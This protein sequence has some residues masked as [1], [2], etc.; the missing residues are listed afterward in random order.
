[1]VNVEGIA[2]AVV[3]DNTAK[4]ESAAGAEPAN[5]VNE[6]VPQEEATPEQAPETEQPEPEAEL[7]P[8]DLAIQ[9]ELAWLSGKGYVSEGTLDVPKLVKQTR[10]LEGTLTKFSALSK[11]AEKLG[12]PSQVQSIVD[13]YSGFMA[14]LQ[15][16]PE[17]R[18]K[19]E[20]EVLIPLR[21]G[22]VPLAQP[23]LPTPPEA[24]NAEIAKEVQAGNMLKAVQMALAHSPIAADLERIKTATAQAQAQA[25]AQARRAK[26]DEDWRGF[27]GG[28]PEIMT[29][30]VHDQ[31]MFDKLVAV[32]YEYDPQGEGKMTFSRAYALAQAELGRVPSGAPKQKPQTMARRPIAAPP[33]RAEKPHSF[34]D[35]T[36]HGLDMMLKAP[37]L[38]KGK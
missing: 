14:A 32:K 24:I 11:L 8:E 7:T 3:A 6:E 29:D 21:G 5:V 28:H 36:I 1:M 13:D 19:F 10:E 20:Q 15:S 30:K 22:Q 34:L 38:R 37:S 31:E 35:S 12:G 9:E 25:Q 4:L 23:S 27:I 18:Q 2:D 17:I 26:L 33:I 16:R